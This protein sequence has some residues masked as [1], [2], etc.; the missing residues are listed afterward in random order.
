MYLFDFED[1]SFKGNLKSDQ[2]SPCRRDIEVNTNVFIK[3]SV[4]LDTQLFACC[5]LHHL[6]LG[7]MQEAEVQIPGGKK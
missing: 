4:S 7:G 3:Y 1:A 6:G 2:T 5:D